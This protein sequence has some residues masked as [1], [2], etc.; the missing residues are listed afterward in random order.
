MPRDT[1]ATPEDVEVEVA[2]GLFTRPFCVEFTLFAQ[3]CDNYI[4]R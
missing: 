1:S 4:G 3:G 2:F